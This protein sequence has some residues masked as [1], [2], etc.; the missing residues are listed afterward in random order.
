MRKVDQDLQKYS[1][2]GNVRGI[3]KCLEKGADINCTGEYGYS[4]L[5]NASW[6]RH[7]EAVE[8][9]L[10][11]NADPNIT[12][13]DNASPLFAAVARNCIE[14]VKILL[15]FGADPNITRDT[16]F[17]NSNDSKGVAPIHTAIKGGK[18]EMAILLLEAGAYTNHI[19]WGLDVYHAA[20]KHELNSLVHYLKVNR[21]RLK[22]SNLLRD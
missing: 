22:K 9:L 15:E 12:A 3:L 20:E 18:E 1:K 13:E 16:E 10:H 2:S 11:N 4:S 8:L 17:Q 19:D 6:G 5:L 14:I 21:Y 7:F